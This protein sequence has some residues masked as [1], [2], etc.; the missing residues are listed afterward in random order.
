MPRLTPVDPATATGEAKLLLDGVQKK[1]GMTPN[2]LRTLANAPSALKAY[3]GFGEALTGGHFEAKAREAFSLAVAGANTCEYCASAH[4]AVSKSLKV[5]DVEIDRRLGGRSADP[6]LDAALAFAVK[7]VDKRGLVSDDDVAA[8]RAAGHDD[9]AVAEIVANV[10][11]NIFTNYINPS[12]KPRS[13]SR[14]S[15]SPRRRRLEPETGGAPSR[16]AASS[17]C[18]SKRKIAMTKLDTHP[19]RRAGSMSPDEDPA[20]S[21]FHEGEHWVQERLGARDIETW[22]RKVVRPYLPEEHRAFHT[23]MPFLIVAARDEQGRPWATV[24]AGDNGFVTSPDPVSLAINAKPVSGDALERSFFS[25]ADIGILGIELATRRRNRVNGRVRRVGRGPIVC[26]VAQ[27]FGN[28]PQYI[29][30]REWRHVGGVPAGLPSRGA[31]LTSSQIASIAAADTFFIASGHRGDE[32]NSAFGMD[33]SHRGGDPGFVEVASETRLVFP[34]YA[35]NNHFNTIGNLV[36]DPRAGFLFVD[37]ETGSLLQLT[38]R[39]TI[40]WDSDAVARTP[41]ARRLVTFDI[42][43]IVELPAVL[44]LRWDADAEPVRSL[45]LIE[46]IGETENVISFVFEARDGGPLSGF[47]AGQHLPIELEIPGREG[48]IRRTY[49]LSGS[50]GD[51]RYRISVKREPRGLASRHLHD[52]FEPK[53]IISSRRP[54]GDFVLSC[55]TCPTVLVSAG[56]GVTPMVSMLHALASE[57]GERPVMFVHGARDGRHHALAHEVRGLA[58]RRAGIRLHVAYSQPRPEDEIGKDY[59]T[60]GRIDGD[61]LASLGMDPDA[62]YYLCGPTRFMADIQSALEGRGVAADHIHTESFGPSS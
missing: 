45:R 11:V 14:R 27:T 50:S 35:G 47:E 57:G 7:I 52:R 9:G 62:H 33:A 36:L 39:A 8:V 29:R 51:H 43:E 32:E 4:V 23:A 49:S 46:K 56:I 30:E 3:L 25:G 15:L 5:D 41:G 58:A 55:A 28:C 31:R 19:L 17:G 18:G 48:P 12:P 2:L 60:K 24:L 59:D 22:A 34:D 1:L 54:A 6:E 16:R 53:S 10:V 21:P 44:P 38:G 61:L 40:D 20:Q 26:E 13:T 37:F 42:E